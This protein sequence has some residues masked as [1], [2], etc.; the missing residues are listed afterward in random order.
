MTIV[1]VVPECVDASAPKQ[2]R[3][4]AVLALALIACAMYLFLHDMSRVCGA[5]ARVALC[6]IAVLYPE[7]YIAGHFVLKGAKPF[8]DYDIMSVSQW[9]RGP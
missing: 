5:A 6:S 7:L 4:A 2:R 9:S 8:E 1:W 3:I